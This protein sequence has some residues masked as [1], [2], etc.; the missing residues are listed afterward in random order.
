MLTS[1]LEI[2]FWVFSQ[3]LRTYRGFCHWTSVANQWH[4]GFS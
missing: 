3:R 2:N 4:S 1:K